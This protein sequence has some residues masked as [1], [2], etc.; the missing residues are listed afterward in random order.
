MPKVAPGRAGLIMRDIPAKF[1]S[2]NLQPFAFVREAE[3]VILFEVF[4]QQRFLV[5]F[6]IGLLEAIY[7]S[8][9]V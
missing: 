7:G 1:F 8:T 5:K 2:R 4:V 6:R 3:V 9:I